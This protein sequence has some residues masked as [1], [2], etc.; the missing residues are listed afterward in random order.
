MDHNAAA[1]TVRNLEALVASLT[2]LLEVQEKVVGEQ[3]ER[4]KQDEEALRE[5]N[6]RF[7]RI[8]QG[9]GHAAQ[10]PA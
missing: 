2:E 6:D 5:S 8:H 1:E 10:E 9:S 3:S 4:L 7:P